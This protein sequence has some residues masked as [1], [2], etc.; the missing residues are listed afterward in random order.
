VVQFHGQYVAAGA[1]FPGS[2]ENIS[3][4][5]PSGCN[6]MVWTSSDE[7]QWTPA[8]G[9]APSGSIPAEQL[10]V[11]PNAVLLFN[12][13]EGTKVWIS[14]NAI[15]WSAVPLPSE[16]AALVFREAVWGRVR[17]V[18]ILN[19]KFAGGLDTAYGESDTIWTSTNG[20]IWTQDPVAGSALRFASLSVDATGFTVRGT[21]NGSPTEW[22][23]PD[24]IAWTINGHT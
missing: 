4:C 3:G 9:S 1:F 5:S 23:S 20:L 16:M 14:T 17:I 12:G 7:K 24:G 10:V 13:D 2:V 6:P 22:I 8:W 11:A 18:A 21:A 19:N 15:S